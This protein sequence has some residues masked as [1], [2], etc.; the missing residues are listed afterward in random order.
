MKTLSYHNSSLMGSAA[1]TDAS[2]YS[3]RPGSS[4][5]GP[6][7]TMI[8]EVGRDGKLLR[9]PGPAVSFEGV[10]EFHVIIDVS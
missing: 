6:V 10:K 8:I 5:P 3:P 7:S 2:L 1:S 9:P 4:D